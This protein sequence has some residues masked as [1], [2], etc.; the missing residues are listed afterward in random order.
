[1]LRN[2]G[3]SPDETRLFQRPCDPHAGKIS[4]Y[5][6]LISV[7]SFELFR[8]I[9]AA[10]AVVLVALAMVGVFSGGGVLS[11]GGLYLFGV[12]AYLLASWGVF[13]NHRWAWRVSI[14]FLVGY[15]ILGA[16]GQISGIP[17]AVGLAVLIATPW[18]SNVSPLGVAFVWL[19]AAFFVIPPMCLLVLAAVSAQGIIRVLHGQPMPTSDL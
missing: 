8:I 11:K 19:H 10:W 6:G 14:A 15:W 4:T 12:Y 9:Q 16:A 5:T 3:L 18:L 13:L 1:M 2:Q 7:G 17:F